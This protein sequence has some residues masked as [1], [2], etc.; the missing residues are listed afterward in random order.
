MGG[1]FLLG[2]L[3]GVRDA[4]RS[5][6]LRKLFMTEHRRM[7]PEGE[8]F[9]GQQS[10]VVCST[11]LV[12]QNDGQRSIHLLAD[13][14]HGPLTLLPGDSVELDLSRAGH[15]CRICFYD[16]GVQVTGGY[17]LRQSSA[18]S[19]AITSRQPEQ[20]GGLPPPDRDGS[21]TVAACRR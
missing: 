4:K 19:A 9:A 17:D 14:L 12:F 6:F 21:P 11:S 1:V 2:G 7:A 13:A 16:G 5:R 18:A 20:Y 15:P 8:L 10:F 3:P